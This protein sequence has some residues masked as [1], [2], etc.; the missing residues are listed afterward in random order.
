MASELD[1]KPCP[2][3]HLRDLGS[4]CG[5]YLNGQRQAP[6][7]EVLMRSRYTAFAL[8]TPQALDYL[9]ETHHPLYREPELRE[10]LQAHFAKPGS[11]AG[12]E[13]IRAYEAGDQGVVEFIAH[14]EQGGRS[15]R[16]H[17]R[18]EFLREGQRWLYLRGS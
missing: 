8:G 2:C 15:D 10:N 4:C 16:M 3:G 1:S 7:P 9:V 5:L 18:S 17:E 14:Y 13:I 11:W 12:L 6:N